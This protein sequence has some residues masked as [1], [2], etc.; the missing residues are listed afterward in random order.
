MKTFH[1]ITKN[2]YA[3]AQTLKSKYKHQIDILVGFE[4][5]WIRP[6]S[7]SLIQSIQAEYPWDIFVGSL[8]HVNT[9][10]ID[11]DR[12]TY[13]KA[14]SKSGGT[15]DKLFCDYFD[16]QYEM[17]QAI[18]P[19]IV[20]HLDVIRLFS[21]DRDKEMADYEGVWE[22]ILMNLRFI[23]SYGGI[24]EINTSALRKGMKEAYPSVS[25]CKVIHFMLIFLFL[26]NW[27]DIPQHWRI[28]RLV[29]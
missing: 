8:H 13:E 20:G 24:L 27:T 10:P 6:S 19:P 22:R 29:R 4:S 11:F 15:D 7:L 9:I 21:L 2:F 3:E 25:I 16:S 14:R 28:I 5:E 1:Q 18:R 26:I 23:R 17:L 12:P